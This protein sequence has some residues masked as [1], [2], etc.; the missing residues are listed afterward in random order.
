MI[1]TVLVHYTVVNTRDMDYGD[2]YEI[3]EDR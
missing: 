2:I 3:V 1:G